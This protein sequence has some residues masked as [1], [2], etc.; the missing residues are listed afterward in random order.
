MCERSSSCI[1]IS[2]LCSNLRVSVYVCGAG[3]APVS[4]SGFG[5]SRGNVVQQAPEVRGPLQQEMLQVHLS[6]LLRVGN[7]G[8]SS[9]VGPA[10]ASILSTPSFST[11]AIRHRVYPL[12]SGSRP[13]KPFRPPTSPYLDSST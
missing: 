2:L 4:V 10:S 7:G 12:C 8:E 3:A 1:P 11:V 9:G 6:T 13:P 5:G